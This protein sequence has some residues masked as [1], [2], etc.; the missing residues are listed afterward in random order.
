M[1]EKKCI[2]SISQAYGFCSLRL[3]LT[4]CLMPYALCPAPYTLCPMPHAPCA[5]LLNRSQRVVDI[6][7]PSAVDPVAYA[8]HCYAHEA[9]N[10]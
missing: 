10:E 5:M 7:E 3:S 9:R 4:L 6:V 2:C 8:Q 1:K